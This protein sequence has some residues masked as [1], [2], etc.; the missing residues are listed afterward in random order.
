MVERCVYSTQKVKP[1]VMWKPSQTGAVL[2][3]TGCNGPAKQC[4]LKNFS[5][6]QQI[7]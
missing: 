2:F 6:L 1:A 5:G 3:N 7:M 4:N